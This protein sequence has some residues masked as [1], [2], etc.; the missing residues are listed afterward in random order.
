MAT[1]MEK[2]QAEVKIRKIS[3]LC[4]FTQSR[5]LPHIL[6]DLNGIYSVETLEKIRPDI[7]DKNDPLRLDGFPNHISCSIE[8]PNTYFLSTAASREKIF[9]DWVVLLIRPGVIWRSENL[10][11]YRNAAS[12]PS[13]IGMG[14]DSFRKIF[15]PSVSGSNGRRFNRE[16]YQLPCCTTDVQ[17]EVLVK[18]VIPKSDIIK[19][20]VATFEQAQEEIERLDILKINSEHIRFTIA[21]HMFD[22]SWIN[23][24][25]AGKYPDEEL[26]F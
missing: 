13:P 25:K 7:V 26:F 8:F 6:G 20:A 1:E 12:K 17:A 14:Y 11:S 5:K 23:K 4:H 22:N 18:E 3:R 10:Y 9:K 2:I 24:V 21:P 19:I 16:A 15:S